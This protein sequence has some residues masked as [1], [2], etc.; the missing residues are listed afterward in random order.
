MGKPRAEETEYKGYPVLKI[1]TG[2]EYKGEEEYITMGVRKAQ[3]VDDCIDAL[4]QFV[5]K[6]SDKRS[7]PNTNN[8]PEE[9]VPF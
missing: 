9:D 7:Q 8:T 3:A 5:D 1:F 2:K 4:R 6:Y